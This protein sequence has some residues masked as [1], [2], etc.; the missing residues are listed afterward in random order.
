[1]KKVTKFLIALFC[2][3]TVG[4]VSAFADP[5]ENTRSVGIVAG[6]DIALKPYFGLQYSRWI[7]DSIG[8]DVEG[9]SFYDETEFADSKNYG[10]LWYY[11]ATDFNFKICSFSDGK[12]DANMLYS[13]IKLGTSGNIFPYGKEGSENDEAVAEVN[14]VIG[15]GFTV[16]FIF[17]NHVSIPV[18]F[19]VI[20]N[21]PF[22]PSV[23]MMFGTGIRYSF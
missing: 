21:F 4:T 1:M 7:N 3:A 20:A 2:V 17:V 8:F 16:D 14:A 23:A 13:W 10:T 12:K 11:F 19:G 9:M 6:G 5:A 22:E 18:N 15:A